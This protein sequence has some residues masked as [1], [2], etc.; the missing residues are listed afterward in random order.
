[1]QRTTGEVLTRSS[2]CLEFKMEKTV[3]KAQFFNFFAFAA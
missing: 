2:G 3:I 1:M